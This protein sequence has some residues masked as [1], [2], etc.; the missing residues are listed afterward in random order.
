MVS[1]TD[2]VSRLGEDFFLYCHIQAQ[3]THSVQREL[4]PNIK[5]QER[6][7][8]HSFLPRSEVKNAWSFIS[9]LRLTIFGVVLGYGGGGLCLIRGL[10]WWKSSAIIYRHILIKKKKKSSS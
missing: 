10:A 9:I 8:D 6:K 4:S 3:P 7:P 5:R 1:T 2:F